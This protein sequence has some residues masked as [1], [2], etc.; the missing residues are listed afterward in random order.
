MAEVLAQYPYS[1]RRERSEG[2]NLLLADGGPCDC[3]RSIR[4][5]RSAWRLGAGRHER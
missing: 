5:P 3:L 4:V 2:E 1:F